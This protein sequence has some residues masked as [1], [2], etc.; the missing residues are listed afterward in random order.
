M[1]CNFTMMPAK[2][3][4]SDEGVGVNLRDSSIGKYAAEGLVEVSGA[5][6]GDNRPNADIRN[7]LRSRFGWTLRHLPCDTDEPL[8]HGRTIYGEQSV[9]F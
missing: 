7:R 4:P 2:Q 9:P 1:N 8:L 5:S 3:R 6:R